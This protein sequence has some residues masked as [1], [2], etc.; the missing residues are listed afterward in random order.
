MRVKVVVEYDG[1]NYSGWQRQENSNS[2]Q[3]EIEKALKK[4]TGR[5]IT[6]HGAGRTDT[7]VHALG[8]VFH[9]DADETI[10][11]ENYAMALNTKIPWDIRAVSSCLVADDFHSRFDST[12][13]HYRYRIIN[14]R[15][16]LAI[17]RHRAWHVTYPL[18]IDK[19]R[20]GAEYL[21][22]EHDFSSFMAAHSD[23]EDTVRRIDSVIIQKEKNEIVIDIEGN[24]FLR[25]MV[26][27]IAGT[28][29][30]IGR[31]TCK[32]EDMKDII[33]S[34]DRSRAGV[35][36]PGHGLYLVEIK[37]GKVENE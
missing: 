26:R 37:Y 16:P 25:N 14:R 10:P 7:D 11:A 28:L 4:L 9:F 22:G 5:D 1:K 21:L 23:I 32:P 20:E 36:A 12:K 2:I 35:T 15:R 3:A 27:I 31:G 34:K 29:V 30:N 18:D 19:M 13:K 8:Q 24:G 6:I 33:S 17:D